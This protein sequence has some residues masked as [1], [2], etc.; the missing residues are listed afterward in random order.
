M[1]TDRRQVYLPTSTLSSASWPTWHHAGWLTIPER[2]SGELQILVHGAGGDHR[3][4]DWPLDPDSYSYVEWLAHRG[5]ASLNLDR[6]G[7]GSSSRPPAAEL[8]LEAQSHALAQ[9]VDHVR[10][11]L[12]DMGSE[13]FSRVVLVGHSMGSVVAGATALRDPAVDAVVLTGYMPVDGTVEMG[14]ELFDFAFEPAADGMPELLGLV[15]EGYLVAKDLGV[16]D[17]LYWA[18]TA[19]PENI[20]AEKLMKGPAARVELSAA[21]IAGAALRGSSLPTL[22]VVGQHDALMIDGS[23]GETDTYATVERVRAVAG[24]N[25]SFAVIEDSGHL[26]NQH[27]NA[28]ASFEA[29]RSWLDQLFA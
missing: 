18:P 13:S 14:D 4:W 9:I 5:V 1:T 25:F 17:L 26:L 22:I 15:G 8:T 29:I 7:C 27:R 10:A 23:L 16:D 6:L 28:H 3:Y 21:A 24:A 2:C 19:D 20:A 12:P 11:G